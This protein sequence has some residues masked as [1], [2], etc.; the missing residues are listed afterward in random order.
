M[1]NPIYYCYYITYVRAF[2]CITCKLFLFCSEHNHILIKYTVALTNDRKEIFMKDTNCRLDLPYP[3][4]AA[5][6]EDSALAERL[7]DLYAGRYSEL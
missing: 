6:K 3:E 7:S 1:K 4:A 2:Q 5:E